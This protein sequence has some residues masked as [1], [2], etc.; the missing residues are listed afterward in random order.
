M[1]T[2]LNSIKDLE[3]K[4]YE[5]RESVIRMLANANAWHAGS[6]LSI[7]D[8]LTVLYF[9]F[10]R[11]DPKNPEWKDRDRFILSKGHGCA[12]LYAVLAQIGYFPKEELMN[13]RKSCGMLEGHP[14]M[15]TTPGVEMSTGC[16]GQGLSA[17]VGMALAGELD[18]KT[19]RIFVLIGDGESQE[20]QI[21]EAAM[22]AAHYKLDNLVC[23]LDYNKCQ[24]GWRIEDAMRIEPLTLKWHSFGWYVIEIDGHNIQEILDAFGNASDV[25]GKPTVIVAH[26]IKGKGVSFM[27]DVVEW[28]ARPVTQEDGERALEE[29]A[30]KKSKL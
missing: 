6:N 11:H 25:K 29:L 2:S 22:A 17:G 30:Y 7:V 13:Y 19:F 14:N 9:S 8:I 20:G 4:T 5:I 23:I 12:T 27:E 15:A 16:L 28:H 24:S 1:F 10:M 18:K 21:W 3:K 26:T